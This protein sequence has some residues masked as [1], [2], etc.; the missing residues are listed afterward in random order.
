[1]IPPQIGHLL[2][3]PDV[4]VETERALSHV[5]ERIERERLR[6]VITSARP[7]R[8][9]FDGAISSMWVKSAAALASIAIALTLL[10]VS[11]VAETI[12]TLFE[13][14][15][16]VAVPIT[17]GDL[18]SGASGFARYGTLTWST[19]PKPYDV[20]NATTAASES[21]LKVLVPAQL[22]SGVNAANGRYGV[23]PRTTTTFTFSADLARQSAA[24][25][26]RTPPPMPA[27]M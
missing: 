7:S 20:P 18:A 2:D 21:G 27:N 14:K 1:M 3:T 22:P 15:Q 19:P 23:M 24:S 26:G 8:G 9:R 10:T 17:S 11:G 16:V 4:H 5:R 6:P 13:P 25:V 12:I